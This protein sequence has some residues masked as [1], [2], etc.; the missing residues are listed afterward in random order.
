MG[1][2]EALARSFTA[3]CVCLLLV[4]CGSASKAKK[5]Q[6]QPKQRGSD[7]V[8][9]FDLNGD[10]KPDLEKVYALSKDAE[11]QEVK[12][13]V[14]KRLDLD[15]NG[16]FDMISRYDESERLISESVDLDFDG[17]FD[18]ERKYEEG[19][20]V[21]ERLSPGFDGNT[22]VWRYF[23]ENGDLAR[24][25]RDTSGNGRPDT[26]EYF[27]EG[28]IVRYGYDRDGDGQPEYFEDAVHEEE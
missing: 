8:E 22:G 23:G 11:G 18:G 14:E 24:K 7:L 13:L 3:L 17:T 10:G 16:R 27:T 12:T 15:H 20:M 9:R 1:A 2:S 26:W 5:S 25:A 28:R 19:Q 4:G 21:E 6:D